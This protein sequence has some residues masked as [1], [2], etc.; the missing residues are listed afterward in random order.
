M[1]LVTE[2]NFI[3]AHVKPRESK[4]LHVEQPE[5]EAKLPRLDY[6]LVSSAV[7]D[8]KAVPSSIPAAFT[9]GWK[10]SSAQAQFSQARTSSSS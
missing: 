10:L 3:D 9:P 4:L 2:S 7:R 8:A 5:V 6:A 1:Q